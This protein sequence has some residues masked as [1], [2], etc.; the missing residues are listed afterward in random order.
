MPGISRLAAC[1]V[2]NDP[3][4]ELLL[5]TLDDLPTGWSIAPL[6]LFDDDVGEGSCTDIVDAELPGAAGLPALRSAV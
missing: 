5:L 1:A 3:E 6:G 2:A 4:L